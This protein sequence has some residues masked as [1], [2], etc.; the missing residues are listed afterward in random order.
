MKLRMDVVTTALTPALSSE[1]RE[2]LAPRHSQTCGWVGRTDESNF[3][4]SQRLFPLLG[5][6]VRVRA[7]LAPFENEVFF[8]P[9]SPK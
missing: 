3:N 6:R 7:G 9:C 5:E 4:G 2:N 8:Q 1:E